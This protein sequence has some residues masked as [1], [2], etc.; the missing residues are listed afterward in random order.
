MLV[1]YTRE[2][3]LSGVYVIV[4]VRNVMSVDVCVDNGNRSNVSLYVCIYDG[5]K[6]C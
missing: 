5:N 3:N 4:M 1:G 2:V 6:L